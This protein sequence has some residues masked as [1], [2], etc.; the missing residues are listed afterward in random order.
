[1]ENLYEMDLKQLKELRDNDD[2]FDKW[3][4]ISQAIENKL[5]DDFDDDDELLIKYLCSDINYAM[6]IWERLY[7]DLGY[8]DDVFYDIE[9]ISDIFGDDIYQ[10]MKKNTDYFD[11]YPYF[12]LGNDK[13]IIWYT[14]QGVIND[15]K[16]DFDMYMYNVY[17]ILQDWY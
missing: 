5:F 6:D 14:K 9:S 15:I 12:R 7:S 4:Y 1:M 2:D 3:D 17:N 8:E 16:L 13:K 10:F 11:K